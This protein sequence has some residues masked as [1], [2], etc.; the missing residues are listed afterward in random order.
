VETIEE[1]ERALG[2]RTDLGYL[3]ATESGPLSLENVA[4][5]ISI[6]VDATAEIPT[7]PNVR[8]T[9]GTSVVAY[10][11]GKAICRPHVVGMT[12]P[13]VRKESHQPIIFMQCGPIRYSMA[14]QNPSLYI[15]FPRTT[16]F[17]GI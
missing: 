14:E 9:R 17:T 10:S 11:G 12:V 7:I 2:P 8:L 4:K 6:P 3:T 16:A 13:P 1:L 15:V 5:G